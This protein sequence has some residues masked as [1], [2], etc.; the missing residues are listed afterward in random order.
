M[1][2]FWCKTGFGQ[3]F[4]D[5][6]VDTCLGHKNG[7]HSKPLLQTHT[8]SN[9]TSSTWTHRRLNQHASPHGSLNYTEKASH[10]TAY[11]ALT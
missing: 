4:L 6:T 10:E 7:A 8:S 3:V 1:Y 11:L 9:Q 2:C 5:G